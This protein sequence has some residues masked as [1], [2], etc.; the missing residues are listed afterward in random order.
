MAS[1]EQLA[2]PDELSDEEREAVE[3]L[4]FRLADDEFVLA[5]RYTEWQVRAP[6]LESDLALANVAQ[7]ELGHARLWYDLLQDFG[8]DEPDLIWERPADEWRHSTLTELPFAEGDWADPVL[9]SYLYDVAEELRLEALV[10]S[11]YA[12]IRDRVGKIQ[13]EEDYHREHAENW[14]ERLA[15][16]ED[17]RKRVQDALDRLFPHA[18]TL[19][20]PTDE[21]IEARIDD[22]GLRTESLV[23]MRE[24]WLE[25][26]VPY[27]EGLGLSVPEDR[28]LPEEI[29]RDKSHT[30]DWDDLREE[31]TRTYRELGRSEA[32]RIMKDPDEVA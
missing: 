30:D 24:A 8:P 32:T 22:L 16:D 14:L 13:G 29:G 9:R 12:R 2:G 26:V 25:T 21:E 5:E 17:G 3:T 1:A 11:S 19:F 10:D 20:A 18:L 27:L 7:D 23:D 31:F 6:T 4:L 15:D 28:D